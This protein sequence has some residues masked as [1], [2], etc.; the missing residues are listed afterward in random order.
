MKESLKTRLIR[1]YLNYITVYRR[2]GAK[3]TFISDDF[4]NVQIK[5]P[6]NW[7][8]TNIVGTIF[9][10]T[11]YSAVDPIYM[12]MFM[13]ILGKDYIVWDKAAKIDFI[14][15]GRD[16]L[17]SE[18]NISQD[19]IDEIKNQLEKEH[20]IT[21]EFTVE[22]INKEKEVSVSIEKTLYFRKK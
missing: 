18:F 1:I 16:V 20:S 6:L 15:P 10:G 4:K 17:S 12:V 21:K 13:N 5:I 3:V 7:N 11:M 14:K 9:G 22:L 8:T 2:T 19:L